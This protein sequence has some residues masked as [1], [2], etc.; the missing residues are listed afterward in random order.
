[1][2][3]SFSTLALQIGGRHR[4]AIPRMLEANGLLER[5]VTDSHACSPAG[6]LASFFGRFGACGQSGDRLLGRRIEGVPEHRITAIN[7]WFLR[8]RLLRRNLSRDHARWLH[9]RDKHWYKAC[10]KFVTRDTNILYTMNGE[11]LSL[12]KSLRGRGVKVLVDVFIHPKNL[13]QTLQAKRA[14][15]LTPSPNELAYEAYERYYLEVYR[16]A[17]VLLCPSSWVAEG[18]VE[19]DQSLSAKV[20]ICPYGSSLA[21]CGDNPPVVPKRVLWVGNDWFRKG[22][23]HIAAAA[24]IL[25]KE[26]AEF[27]IRIAGITPTA[28]PPRSDYRHL[29]F[30]GH[31]DRASLSSEY[32][33]AALFVLP[34]LSEGMASV[35]VE[36]LSFGCPVLATRSSGIDNLESFRGGAYIES[37]APA[38]LARQIHDLSSHP[39]VNPEALTVFAEDA[40]SERLRNI[41]TR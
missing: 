1:M 13:W 2:S 25:K 7:T 39:R 5:F 36:A 6:L 18:V 40:W 23:H 21:S 22:L 31:L 3:A 30:L 14:E 11:N 38:A 8:E 20:Q 15:G 12:Q 28:I 37:L 35:L 19:L 32:A 34:S 9:L 16:N 10:K 4:Y 27:D 29:T 24:A 41:I 17:D 26:D 33:S